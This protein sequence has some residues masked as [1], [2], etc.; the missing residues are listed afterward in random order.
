MDQKLSISYIF[1]RRKPSGHKYRYNFLNEFEIPQIIRQR[2][3][4]SVNHQSQPWVI[5]LSENF[6]VIY[7][8]CKGI[9]FNQC[10]QPATGCGLQVG[11]ACSDFFSLARGACF[12]YKARSIN[13]DILISLIAQSVPGFRW[14]ASRG[15]T[16]IISA[17]GQ[18]LITNE[19]VDNFYCQEES[20]SALLQLKLDMCR[21]GDLLT[22]KQRNC[23]MVVVA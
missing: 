15:P 22:S 23:F 8:I 14:L 11:M 9:L 21:M 19:H 7:N 18:V 1:L 13:H 16:L 12:S 10:K 2:V 17:K 5:N 6:E 4:A 20:D 3:L